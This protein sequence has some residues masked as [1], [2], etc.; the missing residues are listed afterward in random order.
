MRT[1]PSR[2]LEAA[3]T[4]IELLVIVAVV[5]ML[6]A[7]VLPAISRAKAR[8]LRINCVCHLKQIGLSFRTWAVDR[9][10]RY[11]MEVSVTNG[12]TMELINGGPVYRYFLVMSNEL[13]SPRILHCPADRRAKLATSFS[14]LDDSKISYFVGLDVSETKPQMALTGDDNLIIDGKPA[15]H[16]LVSISTN[17]T[18][19]WSLERH[20]QQ[21]NI[22]LADGSVQQFTS[23]RLRQAIEATGVATNRL[24]MP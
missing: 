12:G 6:T 11:P 9:S 18:M 10:D 15:P 4:L 13:S 16:G 23:S 21:G 2:A 3:F 7:I 14:D 19:G 8:S 22:G 20:V 24:A 1:I 17:N 5:V